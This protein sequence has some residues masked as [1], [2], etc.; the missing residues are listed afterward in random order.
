MNT[1]QAEVKP[2]NKAHVPR[3][4]VAIAL[5]GRERITLAKEQSHHLVKVLRVR[6]RD[7]AIL[8]NGDGCEYAAEIANPDSSAVELILTG[9]EVVQRESPLQLTLAQAIA[10]GD[11]MDQAIAKA[12]ELGV[13]AVQPLF[14]ERGKVRLEGERLVKKQEHWQRIAISA[15]EQCGRTAVPHIRAAQTLAEFLHSAPEGIGLVLAPDAPKT[16]AQCP[17]AS[18][19]TLLVG[20]ESGLSKREVE[21]AITAGYVGLRF[22]PRVLRTETAGP[23]CLAALQALWGDLV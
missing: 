21:L 11:R 1:G 20:P 5:Q 23:A 22:G 18:V 12:V 17:R 4:Y 10:R 6:A 2:K 3:F 9:C 16:L 19:A 15:A 8:F 13:T 14:A 7:P